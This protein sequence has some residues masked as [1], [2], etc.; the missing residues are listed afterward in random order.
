MKLLS[1]ISQWKRER[2]KRK[3]QRSQV[4]KELKKIEQQLMDSKSFFI[5]RRGSTYLDE[6]PPHQTL[7]VV[8][9]K[10]E[11]SAVIGMGKLN[12]LS[13]PIV[14]KERK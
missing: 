6:G 5:S 10:D 8:T 3:L 2:R 13:P 11:V 4:K 12:S 9:Y 1:K 14:F 7:T